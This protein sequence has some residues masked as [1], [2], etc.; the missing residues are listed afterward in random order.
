MSLAR[1]HQV[2]WIGGPIRH[3]DDD[4]DDNDYYYYYYYYLIFIAVHTSF[5]KALGINEN[6]DKQH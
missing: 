6:V 4:D 1:R 3:D 2:D 5:P